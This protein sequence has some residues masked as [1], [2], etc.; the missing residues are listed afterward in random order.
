MSAADPRWHHGAG[1]MLARRLHA[2]GLIGMLAWLL[3]AR[4]WAADAGPLPLQSPDVSWLRDPGGRLT[5]AQVAARANGFEPLRG[6]LS[7][8]F[9]RDVVWLKVVLPATAQGG[10]R[11]LELWPG[12][13]DDVRLYQAAA[14][15]AWVER[16]SGNALPF[17]ARDGPD[18]RNRN[19]AF[20]LAQPQPGDVLYLR[21]RTTGTMVVALRLWHGSELRA[22]SAAANIGYGMHLGFV[23]TAVLFYLG[24]WLLTRRALYGAFSLLVAVATLR[25]FAADGLASQFL[26]PHDATVP[27]LATK[28]LV[29]LQWACASLFVIC[30]LQLRERAPYL[31]AYYRGLMLMGL[32][33]ALSSSSDH[34]GTAVCALYIG[35][36]LG[37]LLSI[38]LYLRLWR[39]GG[40]SGRL[41]AASLSLYCLIILPGCLGAF[42]LLPL[43]L[44]TM[45]SAHL[46]DL[47]LMLTLHLTIVLRVR[48]AESGRKREREQAC[49]AMASSLRERRAFEEQSRL[50]AM[51]THEVRTPVAVIDAAAY[52][53]RLLDDIGGDRAQRESRYQ[54]IQL[55]VRRLKLLMELAEARE[56]L[57]PGEQQL[58]TGPFGFAELSRDVLAS[59]EPQAAA[60]VSLEA[61]A[62][63]PQLDGDV[64]LLHFALLN[65]LDN[66]LKYA[67]PASRI[68][69]DIAAGMREG[70]RGVAWRI[71]DQGPGIPLGKED[72]IF[73][74][75]RRLG[76]IADQP[77]LGLGLPLARKIMEL[78][79]GTLRCDPGWR[80]GACFVAWLPEAA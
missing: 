56:R 38:P 54:S 52:S 40:A 12:A 31:L 46:L 16:R 23:A 78:H 15:G 14:N 49:E 25:W 60:R 70:V 27:L 8:G 10:E 41:V 55:A 59:L 24:G 32:A 65:L 53:L 66:A 72:V 29:G 73:E 43:S 18:G 19:L 4:A 80:E 9:T 22:A 76:E 17:E 64:R 44:V 50:L 74:K 3:V 11:W 51:M 34:Y 62:G 42:G 13:L 35:V 1:L 36:L 75:F 20:R 47:P 39:T 5:I 68:L 45:Q 21:I 7:E 58:D 63:L 48:E 79:G 37:Q 30:L 57:V 2:A 69:I 6:G 28:A 77:G 71:R 67:Y 33:V 26:F 61:G